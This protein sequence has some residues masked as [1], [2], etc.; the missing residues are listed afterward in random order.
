MKAP[1]VR[2]E[3]DMHSYPDPVDE[4]LRRIIQFALAG[5]ERTAGIHLHLG[6]GT[7][8]IHS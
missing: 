1:H 3:N 8:L 2:R 6:V 5:D 4:H 7:A